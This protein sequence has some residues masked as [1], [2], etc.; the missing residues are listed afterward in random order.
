METLYAALAVLSLGFFLFFVKFPYFLHD[1]VFIVTSLRIRSK[2]LKF[3]K[4]LPF[5]TVLDCFLDAV[6]RHPHKPFIVFEDEVYTYQQVDRWSNRAA[7]ALRK[8]TDLRE[9]DTAALLMANEP[10]LVFLWI[11]LMKIGCSTSFL[12]NNIRGKS[13][14]HC[15]LCCDAKVLIAGAGNIYTFV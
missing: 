12:N 7:H 8:H 11:G 5:Y 13:L 14:M 3:Q 2:R 9:G 10:H 15:F 6:M 1:C 4:R